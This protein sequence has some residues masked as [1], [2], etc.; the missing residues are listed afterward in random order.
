MAK[1]DPA[2]RAAEEILRYSCGALFRSEQPAIA[3]IIRQET[4]CDRLRAMVEKL[5]E[6]RR[7]DSACDC[8]DCVEIRDLLEVNDD[9]E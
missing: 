9:D 8:R 1:T 4:K 5:A 7:C 3:G 2:M 6:Y